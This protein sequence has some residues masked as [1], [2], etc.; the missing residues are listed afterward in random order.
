[1]AE[2][3]KKGFSAGEIAVFCEQLSLILTSDIPLSEGV[4]AMCEDARGGIG[5]QAFA[6][7]NEEMQRSGSLAEAVAA[8]GAF[9]VYLVGMVRVGEEA[10][11]LE[12]VLAGLAEHY[13]REARVR[14][15]AL[16]A[17]RYPLTLVAVMSLVVLVLV[18]RVLPI[19]EQAL[20]SLAGGLPGYSASMMH[21]GQAAGI[22]VF[23]VLALALIAAL[24]IWLLI[25]GGRRPALREKLLR[26]VPPLHRL[27]GLVTAQ[28]FASVLGMLLSGGFPLEASLELIPSVFEGER[29]R[30]MAKRVSEQ[31]LDGQTVYE[32]VAQAGIF[33][34]LKLRMIRVGFTSGQA[35]AAFDKVAQLLAGEIDEAT[36]RL[37]ARLEPMLVALLSLMIG[38]I[39]LAVMMP[40]AGVLSAMV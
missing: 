40:L 36:G 19:F 26:A 33:D 14:S 21:I 7:M 5:A 11:Q 32:A 38:A 16:S 39:L 28:R 12:R 8:A 17:V 6:A 31:V 34:T 30:A 23:A 13:T 25:R 27:Q 1:M 24:A 22:V 15:T 4:E 3:M 37:I 20:S 29:E 9:P 18:L 2:R 35:D 10:G